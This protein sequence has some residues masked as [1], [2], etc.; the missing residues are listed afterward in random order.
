MGW[1]DPLSV[2]AIG[3]RGVRNES[4]KIACI[5][6]CRARICGCGEGARHHHPYAALVLWPRGGMVLRR[7]D[8]HSFAGSIFFFAGCGWDPLVTFLQFLKHMEST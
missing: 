6:G 8:A 5:F 1:P 3:A 2:F 7:I 4:S